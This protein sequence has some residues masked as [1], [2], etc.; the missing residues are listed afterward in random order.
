M[1][2]ILLKNNVRSFLTAPISA[3]DT[4]IVVSDGG[5]FPT[6]VDGDAFYATLI[7][8]AGALEVVKVTARAGNAMTVLRGQDGSSAASFS[9]GA[10]VE[11][12][13]NAGAVRD[14]NE[15][16]FFYITD[17]DI[18]VTVSVRSNAV[19]QDPGPGPYDTVTLEVI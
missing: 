6:L 12:R 3:T 17:D 2:T 13:V 7:S 5:Q 10:L 4:G 11:M 8:P 19:F 1:A 15:G 9:A 16:A 14:L 18:S